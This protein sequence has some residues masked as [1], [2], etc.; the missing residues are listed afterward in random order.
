MA[1][2]KGENRNWGIRTA[3]VHAGEGIDPVTRASSPNLVMSSTFAPTSF[4]GFSALNRDGYD[5]F[6]YGRIFRKAP[7]D[8]MPRVDGWIRRNDHG[9]FLP[10]P[11]EQLASVLW[12]IGH[13]ESPPVGVGSAIK[14]RFISILRATS[15]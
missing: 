14:M 11:Y 5:G 3:A 12:R 1:S 7:L 9:Q 6:V 2:G 13:G 15:I 4:A 8:A 10:Q